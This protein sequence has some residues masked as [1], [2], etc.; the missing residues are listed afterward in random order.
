MLLQG[1]ADFPLR[2][3]ILFNLIFCVIHKEIYDHCSINKEL[4]I[5]QIN[6]T[7]RVRTLISMIG[8]SFPLKILFVLMLIFVFLKS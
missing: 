1:I 3:I 5:T 7:L 6:F 4:I 2:M 8:S